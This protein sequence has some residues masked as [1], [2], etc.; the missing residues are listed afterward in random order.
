MF[1][2][3]CDYHGACD[4]T[5]VLIIT[6]IFTYR[7]SSVEERKLTETE[8]CTT[9]PLRD[10][11]RCSE[12]GG[13]RFRAMWI[14]HTSGY[15][16]PGLNPIWWTTSPASGTFFWTPVKVATPPS[17]GLLHVNTCPGAE[18]DRGPWDLNNWC[19]DWAREG[20]TSLIWNSFEDY[21]APVS[22]G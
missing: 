2:T 16:P 9:F 19:L 8:V 1:F 15:S 6:Q 12:S 11:F 13:I 18:L 4:F 3:F 7:S 20:K 17:V 21:S 10:L 22:E 14:A 5:D